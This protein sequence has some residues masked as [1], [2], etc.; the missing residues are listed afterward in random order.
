MQR[1]ITRN[2]IA[3]YR[4]IAKTANDDKLNEMILDVQLLDL[5]PLLGEI[6]FNKIIKSPQDYTDLLD[7]GVYEHDGISYTNYG[8]K[9]VLAYFSYARYAAFGSVTDTPFSLV[10]KLANESRPATPES[11]K[12]MYSLNR[13]TALQLWDNVKNYLIRSGEDDFCKAALKQN[14]NMRFSKIG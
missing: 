7:G 8:L 4:Q 6:L 5:Q 14:G 11:K 10:E 12:T 13:S 9:M 1:L 3:R 2:D